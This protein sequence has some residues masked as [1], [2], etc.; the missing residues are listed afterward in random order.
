MTITEGTEQRLASLF[1]GEDRA[2]ARRLL[3]TG[4]GR[5]LPLLEQAS[6]A[7]LERVQFAALKVSGG[8]LNKLQAAVHLAQQDWRDLLVAAGFAKNETAHQTWYPP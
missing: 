8:E 2:E 6:A 4:C 5:N 1:T 3:E 7:E